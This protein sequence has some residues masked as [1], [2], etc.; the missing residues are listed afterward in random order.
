MIKDAI[1]IIIFGIE[2]KKKGI[3]GINPP[4]K[5]APPLTNDTI[6]PAKDSAFACNVL[7]FFFFFF[8]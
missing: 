8:F 1:N 4:R 7:I 6:I 2:M 3:R 5:G